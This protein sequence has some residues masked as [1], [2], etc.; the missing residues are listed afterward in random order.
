M[1]VV[2]AVAAVNRRTVQ[3]TRFRRAAQISVH[4]F[5]DEHISAELMRECK[6]AFELF[7]RMHQRCRMTRIRTEARLHDDGFV[8]C[9]EYLQ[10]IGGIRCNGAASYRNPVLLEKSLEQELIVRPHE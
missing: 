5:F 7:A 2:A 4:I 6:S 9:F 1:F 3:G 10:R 8:Q